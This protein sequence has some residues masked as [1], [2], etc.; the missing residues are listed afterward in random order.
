M[1]RPNPPQITA[2]RRH[3]RARVVNPTW[4]VEFCKNRGLLPGQAAKW[5]PDEWFWFEPASGTHAASIRD[6]SFTCGDGFKKLFRVLAKVD[7]GLLEGSL[8]TLFTDE[9]VS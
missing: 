8:G 1:T 4:A 7:K 3:F 5:S 9:E 6:R 2:K